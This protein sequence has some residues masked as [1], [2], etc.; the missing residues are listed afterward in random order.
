M[1]TFSE[2]CHKRALQR[3]SNIITEAGLNPSDYDLESLL[4]EGLL[5]K[6]ASY[7]RKMVTPLALAAAMSGMPGMEPR[8]AV[9]QQ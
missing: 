2:Y 6:M 1:S 3:I 9:K 7:G 8:P 5:D 4:K